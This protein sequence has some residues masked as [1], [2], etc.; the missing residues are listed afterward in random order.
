LT[1]VLWSTLSSP[2]ATA[3]AA[4]RLTLAG[5]ISERTKADPP[6]NAVSR[7]LAL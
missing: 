6:L 5:L 1:F 4:E 7:G 2:R 3:T